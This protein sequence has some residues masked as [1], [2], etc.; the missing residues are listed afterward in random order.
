MK[1]KLHENSLLAYEQELPKLTHRQQQILDICSDG[2]LRT[3]R[4]IM[5]ELGLPDMNNVR[6]RITELIKDGRITEMGKRVCPV[7]RKSVRL[8]GNLDLDGQL[9]IAI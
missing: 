9:R 5:N 7:T 6:P 8:V 4:Q 3:D 2:R 1:K